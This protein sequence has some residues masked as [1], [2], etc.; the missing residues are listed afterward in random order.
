MPLLQQE[1]LYFSHLSKANNDDFV[2]KTFENNLLNQG[3]GK[4]QLIGFEYF[5]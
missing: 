3:E 2:I 4:I 1:L 5:I